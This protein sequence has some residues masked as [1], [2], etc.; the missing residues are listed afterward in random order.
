MIKNGEENVRLGCSYRVTLFIEWCPLNNVDAAKDAS[1][2]DVKGNIYW[3]KT[4]RRRMCD[5]FTHTQF[6]FPSVFTVWRSPPLT[7]ACILWYRHEWKLRLES[8]IY[9]L[10]EDGEKENNMLLD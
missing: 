6:H 5:L 7:A 9:L 2:K 8:W 10:S 4:E 3:V 1:K